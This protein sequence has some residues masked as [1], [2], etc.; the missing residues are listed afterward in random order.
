ML[1]SLKWGPA[2]NVG[3]REIRGKENVKAMKGE[4]YWTELSG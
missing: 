2:G 1:K 4:E 3:H